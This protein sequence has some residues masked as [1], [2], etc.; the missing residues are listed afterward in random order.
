MS[1]KQVDDCVASVLEDDPS[2]PESR[3]WAICKAQQEAEADE[4]S[5][6]V[7]LAETNIPA[8]GLDE[9]CERRPNEWGRYE[10]QWG[11]AWIGQQSGATIY[12]AR[13]E[14]EQQQ[15]APSVGELIEQFSVDWEGTDGSE[16]NVSDLQEWVGATDR[17][18]TDAAVKLAGMIDRYREDNPDVDLGKATVSD[19]LDWLGEQS[20]LDVEMEG[21][22]I[23]VSE[24]Q[25]AD[26]FAVDVLEVR[27]NDDDGPG[28]DGDLLG[29]GV[30]M[31]NADV[32]ID[33]NIDAWPDD[34]QLSDAHVSIY[35]T[36]EGLAQAT[37]NDVDVV[38]TIDTVE[39]Q[40]LVDDT[41]P[42]IEQ[43][44][45]EGETVTLRGLSQ[46]GVR[47]VRERFNVDLVEK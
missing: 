10:G 34:Q 1:P 22:T 19:L 33:W 36:V 11:V 25:Q 40:A 37:G 35:G 12:E 31:P 21:E 47:F 43:Q 3:A 26:D 6:V 14:S 13:S 16:P 5:E 41:F 38:D 15:D 29:M 7:H 28:E 4:P 32:Y 39:A 18:E 42:T 9:L 30:D 45:T 46:E 44:E 23:V 27:Q 24:Q 2:M 17:T 8:E 20:D